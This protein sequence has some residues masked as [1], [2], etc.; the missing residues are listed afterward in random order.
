MLSLLK[1][2][3]SV[4]MKGIP[5]PR[6]AAAA[7]RMNQSEAREYAHNVKAGNIVGV[8]PA[9]VDDCQVCQKL[10]AEMMNGNGAYLQQHVDNH[11]DASKD[12]LMTYWMLKHNGPGHLKATSIEC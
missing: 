1:T 5:S 2:A 4:S 8:D 12:K 7:K 11:E 10:L 6:H 3:K 9:I